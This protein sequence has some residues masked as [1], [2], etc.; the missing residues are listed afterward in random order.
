MKKWRL[1]FATVRTGR[2][3]GLE[4]ASKYNITDERGDRQN[5]R[6]YKHGW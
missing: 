6:R 4:N 2:L 5:N 1:C 3:Y